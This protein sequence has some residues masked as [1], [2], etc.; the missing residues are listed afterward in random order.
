M[1]YDSD[2]EQVGISEPQLQP[3]SE[4]RT[5]DEAIEDGLKRLFGAERDVSRPLE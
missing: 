2:D 1:A 5:A 3:T 4:G